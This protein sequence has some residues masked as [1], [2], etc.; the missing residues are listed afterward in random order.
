MYRL[1]VTQTLPNPHEKLTA[2]TR[3]T[4]ETTVGFDQPNVPDMAL[5]LMALGRIPQ[6]ARMRAQNALGES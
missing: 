2:D 6:R 1:F 5:A 4:L 3:I